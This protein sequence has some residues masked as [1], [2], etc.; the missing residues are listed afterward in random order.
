MDLCVVVNSGCVD[1]IGLRSEDRS[2]SREEETCLRAGKRLFGDC[3]QIYHAFIRWFECAKCM[4]ENCDY[5]AKERD[6]GKNH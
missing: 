3:Q 5:A 6:I 1:C 2:K 4:G